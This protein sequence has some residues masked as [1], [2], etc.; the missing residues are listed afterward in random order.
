VFD[1]D[2]TLVDYSRPIAASLNHARVTCG[3]PPVPADSVRRQV[4][5][6]LETLISDMVGPGLVARGVRLFRERYSEI[7]LDQTL[8][9]PR[10]EETL[11][12]LH[13]AGLPLSVASNKP[14]RFGERILDHLRVGGYFC[15][16]QGP[17]RVGSTKPEPTMIR[18]CVR[19]M[20]LRIPDAAYVG[21]MPLDV[22]SAARAGLPVVLV[23]TGSADAERLAATG[24]L[25]LTSLEQLLPLLQIHRGSAG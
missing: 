20:G 21:D 12:A 16:V 11:E 8:L 13:G 19:E 14:A 6:G 10:V 4:G 24:E 15:T 3:L 25:V 7:F 9:L 2:G 5:R 18:T 1:L 22:E 23:G 17:D